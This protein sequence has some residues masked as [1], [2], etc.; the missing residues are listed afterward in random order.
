MSKTVRKYSGII[1]T[2]FFRN[3]KSVFTLN[4]ERDAFFVVFCLILTVGKIW[5]I[6]SSKNILLCMA[7]TLLK[8][9]DFLIRKGRN[10]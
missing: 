6:M 9:F 7:S 8:A 3:V 1:F 4:K 5:N 10:L 2:I